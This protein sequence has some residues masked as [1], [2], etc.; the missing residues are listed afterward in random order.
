MMLNLGHTF[1]HAIEKVSDFAVPNGEAVAM[2]LR[3]VGR[4]VPEI[5]AILDSYGFGTMESAGLGD[6][7]EDILRAISC[8][9]KRTGDS[10]T[11]VVPAA[12][13]DCRLESVPVSELGK[14][15]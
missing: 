11:L 7:R 12:L 4:D 15:L 5:G 8:D 13:G 3:I 9:K 6:A 10:V 2:G 14:W 1:G